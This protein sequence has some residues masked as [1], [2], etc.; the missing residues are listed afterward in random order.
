MKSLV[1]LPSLALTL[2]AAFAQDLSL[3]ELFR[4]PEF[5]PAHCTVK[6]EMKFEGG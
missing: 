2:T 4:R 3:T 6:V 5:W 1:L